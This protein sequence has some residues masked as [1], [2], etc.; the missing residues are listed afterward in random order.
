[1]AA[2][3]KSDHVINQRIK[4]L[5]GEAL[6]FWADRQAQ[7]LQI[8]QA[9]AV[10][11]GHG[12]PLQDQGLIDPE[13]EWPSST[14]GAVKLAQTAGGKVTRVGIG[15]L[16]ERSLGF[17]KAQKISLFY[18]RFAAHHQT[19]RC[20][21]RCPCPAGGNTQRHDAHCAQIG[22]DILAIL[23][24]PTGGPQDKTTLFKVQHHG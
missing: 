3:A 18:I 1:M 4:L 13:F 22:G 2:L 7:L 19:R 10:R 17:V 14:G 9:L 8:G 20:G 23:A 15:P 6:Q 12:R 11:R 5:I 21:N 16:T 24:I